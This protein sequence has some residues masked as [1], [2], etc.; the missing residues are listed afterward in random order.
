MAESKDRDGA[1]D[2]P[3]RADEENYGEIITLTDEDG[4]DVRF[5]HLLT[6]RYLGETYIAL[7]PL[8][9]VEWVNDGEVVLLRIS[10]EGNGD[11]LPI[12]SPVMLEEVFAVFLELFDEML[13]EQEEETEMPDLDA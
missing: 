4:K 2:M 13:D 6:F 8:E 1:E 10:K 11:Y 3:V 12:E 7:L 5:D 9:A